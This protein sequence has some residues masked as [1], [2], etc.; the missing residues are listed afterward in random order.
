M[1][2]PLDYASPPIRKPRKQWVGWLLGVVSMGISLFVAASSF[3]TAY[4]LR[5]PGGLCGFEL[6]AGEHHFWYSLPL[7]EAFAVVGWI[8]CAR[9]DAGS[10]FCRVG[11]AVAT[12]L[13]IGS[14]IYLQ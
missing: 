7:M 12:I 4:I 5:H 9:L 8:L 2:A 6:G 13:W 1:D 14:C 11:V 3:S 10:A